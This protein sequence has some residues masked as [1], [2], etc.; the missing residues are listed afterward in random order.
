MTLPTSAVVGCIAA[1]LLAN[2]AS[3]QTCRGRPGFIKAMVVASAGAMM[4][5]DVRS[6]TAGLTAGSRGEGLVA[7]VAA[8]HVVR[9]ASSTFDSDQTGTSL[10]ASIAYSGTEMDGRLELCPGIGV[11]QIRVSGEFVAGGRATLTQTSRRAGVSAGYTLSA[12][13]GLRVIPFASVEYVWF[14]GSVKGEGVDFAVP[15]DTYVPVSLGLGTV[16]SDRLGISIA[17]II[18]TGLESAAKSFVAT[19]SLALGGRH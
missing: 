5:S 18:P 17:V 13:P 16:W 9:K 10:G 11:S 8:G 4:A 7:S 12:S 2:N 14:G 6:T 3:A 1:A 15:E 19:A